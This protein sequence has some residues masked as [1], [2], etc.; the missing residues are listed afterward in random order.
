[1]ARSNTPPEAI[2]DLPAKTVAFM[3]IFREIAEDP[4]HFANI[5]FERRLEHISAEAAA[6]WQALAA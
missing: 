4:A 1:M 5:S 3:F 2:A 6:G